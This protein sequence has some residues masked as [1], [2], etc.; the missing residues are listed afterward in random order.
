[1]P[2]P[3]FRF[4][5]SKR[6]FTLIELLIAIAIM[7]V[8]T[9][10]AVAG[11]NSFNAR[12]SVKN[13]ALELQTE[14]RKYQNYASAGQKKPIP[15]DSTCE[16]QSLLHYKVRNPFVG[17]GSVVFSLVCGSVAPY[18]ELP[19]PQSTKAYGGKPVLLARNGTTNGLCFSNKIEFLPLNNGIN[20]YCSL[21]ASPTP[22]FSPSN[23]GE[24]YFDVVITGVANYRVYVN[25]SGGIY[26]KKM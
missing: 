4:S 26:V 17:G 25:T 5:F 7:S 13:A 15:S 18:T 23:P 16:S 22:T 20:L 12:Q 19:L 8:I 10:I 1:M 11:Y 21:V 24:I 9:T 14:L 2:N 3:R 6:G